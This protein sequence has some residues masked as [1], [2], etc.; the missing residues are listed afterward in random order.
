M[1]HTDEHLRSLS[2]RRRQRQTETETTTRVV[3]DLQE[4]QQTEYRR[5]EVHYTEA[6]KRGANLALVAVAVFMVAVIL[7]L[8]DGYGFVRFVQLFLVVII[9]ALILPAAFWIFFGMI[10]DIT[11][12]RQQHTDSVADY[13][14]AR[15]Q[16]VQASHQL[17]AVE[18]E[19]EYR[20]DTLTQRTQNRQ[21][22]AEVS[23]QNDLATFAAAVFERSESPSFRAWKGRNMPS[24]NAMTH[25]RWKVLVAAL[26]TVGAL[27]EPRSKGQPYSVVDDDYRIVEHKLKHAGYLRD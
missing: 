19:T 21:L 18:V 14:R 12:A 5:I 23:Q 9:V 4:A 22:I 8:L 1:K 27:Q 7:G 2:G 10:L 20:H 13:R 11:R 24:G 26:V 25:E 16:Y 6:W 17:T 3:E 15:K